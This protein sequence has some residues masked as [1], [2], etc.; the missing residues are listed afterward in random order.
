MKAKIGLEITDLVEGERLAFRFVL[1]GRI[2]LEGRLTTCAR[3]TAETENS[4]QEG[5]AH[6]HGSVADRWR[7]YGQVARFSSGE[8]KELEKLKAVVESRS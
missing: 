1:R 5:T 2:I 7:V 4:D 3:R 6:V 8:I